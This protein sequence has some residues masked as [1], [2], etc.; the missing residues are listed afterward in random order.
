[1]GEVIWVTQEEYNSEV[2]LVDSLYKRQYQINNRLDYWKFRMEQ[3]SDIVRQVRRTAISEKWDVETFTHIDE[4]YLKPEIE[5]IRLRLEFWQKTW[6]ENYSNLHGEFW[7]LKRKR[8]RVVPPPPKYE[9]ARIMKDQRVYARV[10]K[11]KQTPDPVLEVSVSCFIKLPRLM[12][13]KE[14]E[15]WITTEDFTKTHPELTE[16]TLEEDINEILYAASFKVGRK[17]KVWK[18]SVYKQQQYEAKGVDKDEVTYENQKRFWLLF[19]RP[20]TEYDHETIMGWIR[21]IR[22]YYSRSLPMLRHI[23]ITKLEEYT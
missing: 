1:M 5:K 10:K 7:R 11:T 2:V 20:R 15:S 22:G 12:T 23:R 21:E 4:G 17:H 16:G 3:W 8:I 13:N 14:I 6:T 19:Y 9:Y 18:E